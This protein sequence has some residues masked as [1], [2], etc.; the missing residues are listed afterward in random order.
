MNV[1]SISWRWLGLAA[2]LLIAGGLLLAAACNDAGAAEQKTAAVI[3]KGKT[4]DE[5]ETTPQGPPRL[6]A[7]RQALGVTAGAETA[8]P[9]APEPEPVRT[10][11]FDVKPTPEEEHAGYLEAKL[12]RIKEEEAA[13][14]ALRADVQKEL[15]QLEE[16]RKQVD[17]RLA[18]EDAEVV[19]K[20]ERLLAIYDKMQLDELAKVLSK[21]PDELRLK[22]LFHMKEKRVSMI[23]ERMDPA[24]AARISKEL[25]NKKTK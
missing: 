12:N 7:L 5:T 14:A 19:K 18:Q 10:P 23:L 9:A 4:A 15:K 3:D 24:E 25:L 22:V 16:V 13:L 17:A 20:V 2:L 1:R 21:L 6:E 11:E 8:K